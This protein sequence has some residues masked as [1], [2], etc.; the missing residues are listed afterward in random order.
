M[1]WIVYLD[2]LGRTMHISGTS[3][4]V[5]MMVLQVNRGNLLIP[6]SPDPELHS[7][8]MGYLSYGPRCSF[9]YRQADT[10]RTQIAM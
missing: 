2:G 10:V 6:I 8:A 5:K 7:L 3:F 9:V 1:A 4:A